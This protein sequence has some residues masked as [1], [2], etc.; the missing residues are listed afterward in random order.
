MSMMLSRIFLPTTNPR[1]LQS[2][3]VPAAIESGRTN[4]SVMSFESLLFKLRGRSEDGERT[5]AMGSFGRL[6]L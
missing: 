3:E 4:S 1:C 5:T 2:T 6:P